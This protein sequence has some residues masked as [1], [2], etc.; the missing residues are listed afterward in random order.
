MQ[1]LVRNMR[2]EL[3]PLK[4]LDQTIAGLPHGAPVSVTCS[5]TKGISATLDLSAQLIDRGHDVVPH[6][7]ARLVEGP[8]HAF[9]LAQWVKQHGVK[10]VLIIGGDIEK[11]VHYADAIS[12]MRDFLNGDPGVQ[13]IGFA[14]YPDGH[15]AIESPKLHTAL[16]AKQELLASARVSG[17]ATTQMCFD[18]DKIRTWLQSE[19]ETGFNLPIKLGLPGVVDRTK[20]MTISLRLGVGASMRYLSKNRSSITQMFAPGGFDPTTLVEKLAPVAEHL[21][22]VGIHSFTFNNTAD[23]ASWQQ[24]ILESQP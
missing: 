9:K 13:A 24:A 2:Y 14:A 15:A 22:I 1:R 16:F 3:F 19:R 8:E 12:F 5:P 20:L 23:T 21:G 18:S 4:T 6:L 11:Q 17:L 10:E 7:D